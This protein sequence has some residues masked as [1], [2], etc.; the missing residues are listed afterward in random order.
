MTWRMPTA[1]WWGS[2]YVARSAIVAAS[3]TVMSAYIPYG[4]AAQLVL[5]DL[6]RW[7]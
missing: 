1:Y 5:P 3:N 2:V 4:N 7:K 6:L